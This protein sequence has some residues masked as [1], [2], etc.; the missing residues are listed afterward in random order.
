MSN[1]LTQETIRQQISQLKYRNLAFIDGQF[2]PARSGEQFET[3]NPATGELLTQVAACDADDVDVAVQA[4]RRVR[5]RGLAPA[6][7]AALTYNAARPQARK[8]QSN[9]RIG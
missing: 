3:L 9:A 6:I 1:A 8:A 5:V 4:A 2:V 7:H